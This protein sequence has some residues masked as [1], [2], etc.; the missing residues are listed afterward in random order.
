MAKKQNQVKICLW[1]HVQNEASIIEQML[2]SAVDYIDYWVLIDN[3]STD[4]TQQIIEDFFK[5]AG[6][7]GKL[8]QSEIGW[9]GHGVNRQHSWEFLCDTDHGCDYILRLD[10]DE[11]LHVDEDFDWSL[12]N[13]PVSHNI[14]YQSGDYITPRTWLWNFHQSFYWQDD[15]AHETIHRKD[16][17][18]LSQV[19]LP[20]SFRQFALSQGQGASSQDPIKYLKDVYKL[21]VQLHERFSKG[22][23]IHDEWYHLF[24]LCRSFIF[25]GY[26]VDEEWCYQYFP[27]GRDSVEMFL[28]RGIGYFD[29]MVKNFDP[30]WQY[31]FYRSSLQASVNDTEKEREDLES[32]HR[33]APERAEPIF[34][35]F[36]HAKRQKNL[37]QMK[38]WGILLRDIEL[39]LNKDPYDVHLLAYPD[40]NEE[41]KAELLEL[42]PPSP[43]ASPPSL[44]K[45]WGA[46]YA[47]VPPERKKDAGIIKFY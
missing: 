8:Y 35:L 38:K 27:F 2:R 28:R 1:T 31:F 5:K 45:R 23:T 13:D 42:F 29:Q 19:C 14:M 33:L 20:F 39:D 37:K 26:N 47:L 16:G 6:V 44:K 4:G 41:L 17:G 9:K 46:K 34:S 18:G 3:G 40:H 11:G 43:P 32:A 10:A 21:E 22:S 36:Q 12:I 24:Y 7:P 30:W 15:E 25:T